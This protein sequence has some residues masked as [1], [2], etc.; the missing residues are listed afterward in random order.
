[1]TWVLDAS[2]VLCWLKAEQGG[3]RAKEVLAG[4]EPVLIHAVNLLEVQYHFLR[5]GEQALRVAVEGV[6]RARIQV[7]REIDDS[8]LATADTR[9]EVESQIRAG[10]VLYLDALSEQNESVPEPQAWAE[11]VEV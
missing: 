6:Q 7:V 4:T 5:R 3:Q 10:I 9:E 11:L 2:A 1:V 8:L